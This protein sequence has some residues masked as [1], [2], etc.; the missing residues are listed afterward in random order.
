MCLFYIDT[1]PV[2]SY[3]SPTRGGHG[4][5]PL[6]F[7]HIRSIDVVAMEPMMYFIIVAEENCLRFLNPNENR[8]HYSVLGR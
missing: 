7:T 3:G 4:T 6:T 5:N 2:R 1:P 8:T